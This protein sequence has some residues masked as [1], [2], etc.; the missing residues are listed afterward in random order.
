MTPLY[1]LAAHLVGD[2]VFQTRWQATEKFTEPWCR[3]RHATTYALPFIPIAVV[4]SP[5]W[6][7]AL[8][9]MI[10]LWF[11]HFLTDSRRFHSTLGD[12]VAWQTMSGAEREREWSRPTYETYGNTSDS[13]PP[14][15][16]SGVPIMVDQALHLVQLAVLGGVFLS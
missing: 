14:N 2:F 9:F 1:L 8:N 3:L 10:A 12:W 13:L 5:R 4:F 7:W 6:E 11:F 15:P 16:W